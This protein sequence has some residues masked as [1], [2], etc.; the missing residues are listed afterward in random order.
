LFSRKQNEEEYNGQ[1]FDEDTIPTKPGDPTLIVDLPDGQKLIVGAIEPGTVI[2]IATWRGTGRP[3]SRTTRML[4]GAGV[5]NDAR[6]KA[7]SAPKSDKN[8][9]VF[10]GEPEPREPANQLLTEKKEIVKGKHGVAKKSTN[11]QKIGYVAAGIVAAISIPMLV[12]NNGLFEVSSPDIGMSTKLGGADSVVAITTQITDPQSG[13]L[14]IATV[15][16]N[17]DIQEVLARVS[18]VGGDR[19]LL[20]ANGIQYEVPKNSVNSKVR[21]V[22]PFFGS[23]AKIF[24][25]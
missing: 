12:V 19:V 9:S 21:A 4:L 6:Q 15:E 20:Q 18:A 1:V 24:G 5:N 22:V 17:G 7:I 16:T 14:V 25:A 8:D 23:I 10:T 3:D 13:D 11:Y 2:E